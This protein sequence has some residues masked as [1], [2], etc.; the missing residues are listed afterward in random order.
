MRILW[1]TNTS[2]CYQQDGNKG[3]NG[4][5]WIASLEEELK[6]C[7][8]IELGV[9]FYA[10]NVVTPKKEVQNGT[11]YYIL[12]RPHKTISYTLK[13]IFNSPEKASL[14]HE[15][16][17]MP[18]LQKVVEDFAPDVIQVFGSENIY[19]LIAAYVSTPVV[20]HIQGILSPY[21]NAFLPPFISWK[22]YLWQNKS[23]KAVLGRISNRIAWQRNSI[24]ERRMVGT[25]KYFMGRT[26]W[27]ERII[28]LLNPKAHYF[29]CDEILRNVFYLPVS[30]R[31]FPDV[32]TFV[33]TIS[34]QLYKGY[35]IILK[36]AM[37]LKQKLKCFEWKVFGD[38]SPA[39]IEKEFHI[40]HENVNVKLMGVASAEDIRE[41][42][43][44]ATAYIHTSYIDNSP[45]SLCEAMLL[46][47]TSIS[48]SV[49]GIPSLVT[50][51]QT[52][53]L[54]PANDPYQMAFL[55]RYIAEHPEINLEIGN[56]ARETA[57]KRHDKNAIAERVVSI[58]KSLINNK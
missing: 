13:T 52:G 36:T 22:M 30:E 34:S 18:I 1:F 51:G 37:I 28:K 45:N 38:V 2:S 31:R 8:D 54:V 49:G 32:P 33:T 26:V 58:Y 55:M 29:H 21:L 3:Y 53:F 50:D 42:L 25:I 43:L 16:I 44:H 48:T 35:D 7:K 57:I 46:G 17:A 47:V 24:T 6:Q 4:G 15:R 27:D 14:N 9:C 40:K 10:N 41:A 23:F 5:G 20:L 12:P 56:A 39:L 11:L 19:G